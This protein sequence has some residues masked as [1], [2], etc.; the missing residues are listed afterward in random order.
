MIK[1]VLAVFGIFAC[2]TG[3]WALAYLK[4]FAWSENAPPYWKKLRTGILLAGIFIG[5]LSW[6]GTYFMGYPFKSGNGKG[7]VVGIPFMV[8]YFDNAGRDYVGPFTMPAVIGNGIFWFLFPHVILA[9]Y[10]KK[11]NKNKS[12]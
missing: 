12:A 1:I 11:I 4:R 6:P 9:V 5:I 7:R 10:A 8:G 2:I 3:F